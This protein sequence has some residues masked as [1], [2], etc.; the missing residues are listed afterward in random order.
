MSNV[1]SGLRLDELLREVQERLAEVVATR[2][3][4]QGLLDAVLAVAS[5]LELEATLRRIVQAGVDLVDARYGALGVLGPGRQISRF[6]YVGSTSRPGRRW[7]PCPRE[8]GCSASS[9]SASTRCGCPTS[10]GTGVGRL[11]AAPSVDAD[12]PR[13]SGPGGG[14]GVRQPVP[15]RE[16]RSRKVGTAEFTAD[17]EILVEAL[18]AA[19]GIAVHNADL[20][21]QS[22]LRQQ[23]LEASAE[24]RTSCCPGR[25]R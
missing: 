1:Q 9:S 22:R 25:V 7:G 13:C 6:I 2:D 12:L 20:F 23:W 17:D 21:E 16:V 15:H 3:R 24:I 11:P 14:R 8:R 10:A 18:A 19:A 4:M 5:G